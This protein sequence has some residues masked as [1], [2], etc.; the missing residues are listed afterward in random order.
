M[1]ASAEI[2]RRQF[3]AG[4]AG[5][6]VLLLV[7]SSLGLGWL[8]RRP[9]DGARLAGLLH[10][11][12]SARIVGQEYLRVMPEE[13]SERVLTSH[14]VRAATVGSM[15]LDRAT[16]RELRQLMARAA[17]QDFRDGRT[18]RLDGWV[19]SLTEARLCALTVLCSPDGVSSPR[20]SEAAAGESAR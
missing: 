10:H 6:G 9:V 14:L 2:R 7:R 15:P 1:S 13:A 8:G 16:D 5:F 4:S 17:T 19:V 18:T 11:Q 12:A 3:L 20:S